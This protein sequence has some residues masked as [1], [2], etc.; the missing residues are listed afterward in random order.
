LYTAD[1]V[2]FLARPSNRDAADVVVADDGDDASL[3]ALAQ[4]NKPKHQRVELGVD[5]MDPSRSRRRSAAS[6]PSK[7]HMSG[8][9]RANI[10]GRTTTLPTIYARLVRSL[11]ALTGGEAPSRSTT[12]TVR[13][14]T[15]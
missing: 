15:A 5:D 9:N 13:P 8:P 1:A 12:K 3:P 7:S 4:L 11:P 2:A 10:F 6:M 14:S